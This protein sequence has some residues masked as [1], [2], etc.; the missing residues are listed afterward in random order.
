M[1][2]HAA[3][4]TNS[5]N[6]TDMADSYVLALSSQSG[7]CETYGYEAGKI[8]CRKLSKNDY[9][10][11]RLSLHGLWPNKDVCGQSYGYCAGPQQN[12]HCDYA[13]LYL[14][15][16]VAEQLK[17]L[18]PSYKHGSC[19]ERHEWNKHGTCQHLLP[20]EYFSLA[21]KLV[22]DVNESRL[23]VYITEH[24]GQTVALINLRKAVNQA[25]GARNASKIFL[26]CKN[27][28]LVEIFIQLPA[29]LA[30]NE[31]V[32]KLIDRAPSKQ[33]RD[34]CPVKVKLSNFSKTIGL[35]E[36]YI[37]QAQRIR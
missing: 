2:L 12:E 15:P 24:V 1:E 33:Y 14:S 29:T 23:G 35:Y 10:A 5:C 16:S 3:N 21:M 17:Q 8:E 7:F 30:S 20:D 13:P 26:G 11:K 27:G 32:A 4:V 31:S 9:A 19:L 22:T 36:G 6:L 34:S 37:P 28:T 18:M 25:F